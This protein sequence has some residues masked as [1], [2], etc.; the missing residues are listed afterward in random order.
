MSNCYIN[1]SNQ[2][3]E[4]WNFAGHSAIGI[5]REKKKQ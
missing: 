4:T 2:K 3:G 1:S 5:N